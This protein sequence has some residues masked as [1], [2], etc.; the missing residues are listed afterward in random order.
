MYGYQSRENI[1]FRI[2][3]KYGNHAEAVYRDLYI[4]YSMREFYTV[5]KSSPDRFFLPPPG[6]HEMGILGTHASTQVPRTPLPPLSLHP[7]VPPPRFDIKIEKFHDNLNDD[8]DAMRSYLA[9]FAKTYPSYLGL[10]LL[11]V[12]LY[13]YRQK[14]LEIPKARETGILLDDKFMI[15]PIIELEVRRQGTSHSSQ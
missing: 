6:T 15:Y 5:F 1:E 11:S 10:P 8:K 14:F 9:Y 2:V 3:G 12:T 7:D 4:P 13:Q